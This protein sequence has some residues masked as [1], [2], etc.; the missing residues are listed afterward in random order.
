VTAYDL[1]AP[2]LNITI[3][4]IFGKHIIDIIPFRKYHT[5]PKFVQA[6]YFWP[7]F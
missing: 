4:G 1:L 5:I 6:P 7:S 2:N 3:H